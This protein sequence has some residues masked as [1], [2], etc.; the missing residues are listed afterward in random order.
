MV[1]CL[2]Q[3]QNSHLKSVL[4]VLVIVMSFQC[5]KTI[6][7]NFMISICSKERVRTI[8][9]ILYFNLL[10]AVQIYICICSKVYKN[11]KNSI[12]DLSRLRSM[13]FKIVVTDNGSQLQLVGIVSYS[14][15]DHILN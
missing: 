5:F 10:K 3:K 7:K 13:I 1:V 8:F 6:L 4:E 12:V 14:K 15:F 11:Q 2:Q 9:G